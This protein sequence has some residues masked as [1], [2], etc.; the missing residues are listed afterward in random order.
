MMLTPIPCAGFHSFDA[1]GFLF[2][3]FKLFI[4]L[5]AVAGWFCHLFQGNMGM[6]LGAVHENLGAWEVE[7]SW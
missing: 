4:G 1:S 2:V 6:N 5:E 7:R 3:N